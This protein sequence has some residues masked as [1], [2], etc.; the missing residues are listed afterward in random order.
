[1]LSDWTAF[2]SAAKDKYSY[3]TRHSCFALKR[4]TGRLYLHIYQILQLLD[5]LPLALPCKR[6]QKGKKLSCH[7]SKAYSTNVHSTHFNAACLIYEGP[8][9][10]FTSITLFLS[11]L[12]C[13]FSFN[14]ATI[15]NSTLCFQLHRKIHSKLQTKLLNTMII[16]DVEL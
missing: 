8:W 14:K 15:F 12:H 6:T 1:M 2:Y 7:L 10:W 13:L 5:F 16:L 3:D 11:F 4:L 9:R